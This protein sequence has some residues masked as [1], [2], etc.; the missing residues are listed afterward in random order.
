MFLRRGCW[1]NIRTILIHYIAKTWMRMRDWGSNSVRS[2][3]IYSF[4][5][6]W[7]NRWEETGY[8][9]G[10]QNLFLGSF[11]PHNLSDMHCLLP[12]HMAGCQSNVV[13][14][15]LLIFLCWSLSASSNNNNINTNNN[16]II[17]KILRFNCGQAEDFKSF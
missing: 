16:N 2:N 7:L 6:T 17:I 10:V 11:C 14:K 13:G 1:P 3:R 9:G 8:V 15:N 12:Y 4:S 5:L